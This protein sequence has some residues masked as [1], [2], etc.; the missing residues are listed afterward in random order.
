MQIN[1]LDKKRGYF[2]TLEGGEGSGKST[3]LGL[4]EDY[5]SKGGYDV[6]FTRED[7]IVTAL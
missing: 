3:Q 2:V 5:L 7:N 1:S 4:L 6:I